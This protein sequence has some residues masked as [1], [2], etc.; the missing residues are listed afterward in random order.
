MDLGW[1]AVGSELLET[2]S[3]TSFSDNPLSSVWVPL[4]HESFTLKFSLFSLL[5]KAL[6]RVLLPEPSVPKKQIMGMGLLTQL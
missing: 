1:R 5:V 6:A 3:S 4:I 2:G